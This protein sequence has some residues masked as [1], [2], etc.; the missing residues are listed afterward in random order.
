MSNETAYMETEESLRWLL[1]ALKKSN[2]D[3]SPVLE[4]IKMAKDSIKNC[5]RNLKDEM[6]YVC[7]RTESA[8]VH[9]GYLERVAG[10][11]VTLQQV[12]RIHYW[13]GAASLSELAQRGVSKP[14][15]CRIPMNVE[16]MHVNKWIEIIPVTAAAKETLENVETWTA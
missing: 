2:I 15:N 9:V 13:D 4:E 7:V 16:R 12:K 11:V 1:Q 10:D 3:L 6:E 5:Q 8:G 14:D